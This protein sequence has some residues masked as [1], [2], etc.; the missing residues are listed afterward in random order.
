MRFMHDLQH[1]L[2]STGAHLQVTDFVPVMH[3]IRPWADTLPWAALVRA[4][5][6]S[7]ARRFPK[8]SPRGRRAVPLRVLFALE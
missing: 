6:Q 1:G 5:A 7:F 2:G 8:K 4:I 3:P